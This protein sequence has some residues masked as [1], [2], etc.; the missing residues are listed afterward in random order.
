MNTRTLRLT[1]GLLILA[2]AGAALGIWWTAREG[3]PPPATSNEPFSPTPQQIERGAYLARAGNCAA[4][5]T[6]R[7]GALYAGGVGIT[8]PFGTVFS[9][10]LTPDSTTGLGQWSAADFWRAMHHG[11]SRSGELLYPAFP[12]TSYT[13]V[14]RDDSDAL[15]AYLRSLASVSRPN[16]PHTLEFPYSSQAALAVWR[17]LF[18]RPAEFEP[19]ASRSAEWN[20]GAYLVRGLGHC[21]ECH[22]QRNALGA[23]QAPQELRGGLM[24]LQHW[25][26]PSLASTGEAGVGQ[27]DVDAT[28]A[29]LKT[30]VAQGRS[31]MG[32]MAEVVYRSTQYLRD[33]DLRAIVVY[34][35]DLP[36]VQPQTHQ[37]TAADQTAQFADGKKIYAL[38]CAECHGEQG[39]GAQGA[40]APLAANRAVGLTT[41][42]NLVQ[43]VLNGGFTPATAANPR[44]Y[45]MPPFRQILDDREVAA[46]LTYIRQAWG[47]AAPPVS[48]LDVMQYQ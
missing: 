6:T 1:L 40:Y 24:P 34:L 11:R 27:D 10:N 39:E 3:S 5:H 13:L 44:P 25:Y 48:P 46:V 9:S 22:A 43:A 19:E 16:Q 8:T 18:F 17:A 26:A 33:S 36:S 23:A 14:S 30:G 4:C 29:L 35:K 20:R 28:I 15:F 2:L 31:A 32:P 47:N 37:G 41:P 38:H 45:G 7:G 21:A 12:Y 42:T